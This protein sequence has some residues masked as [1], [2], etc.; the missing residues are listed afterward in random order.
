MKWFQ[1]PRALS[2]GHETRR[3]VHGEA[4]EWARGRCDSGAGAVHTAHEGTG[5]PDRRGKV[6]KF[7]FIS[8]FI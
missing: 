3:N 1:L 7:D 5:H 8:F 4:G 6:L 2:E